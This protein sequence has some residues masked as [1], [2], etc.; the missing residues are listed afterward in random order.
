MIMSLRTSVRFASIAFCGA[1]AFSATASSDTIEQPFL[2]S[3][4]S[5]LDENGAFTSL[6]E[7]SYISINL[8]AYRSEV[9][10]RL[11]EVSNFVLEADNPEIEFNHDEIGLESAGN[12]DPT[13]SRNPFGWGPSLLDSFVS[14]GH[15]WSDPLLNTTVLS[16]SGSE[17]DPDFIFGESISWANSDPANGQG[18]TNPDMVFKEMGIGRFVLDIDEYR[19]CSRLRISADITYVNRHEDFSSVAAV[20]ITVGEEGC[21]LECSADLD[22]NDAVDGGD[23]ATL[24]GEWGGS[25]S[26]D[27][28]G[29]GIVDGAD[30]SQLLGLWGPCSE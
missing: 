23:L 4:E 6:D 12:W 14:I 17:S 1:A 18:D 16:S 22:G 8:H 24:L 25:G 28:N 19:N 30:L 3:Y 15:N 11:I 13:K 5:Y 21:A 20:F 27:L 9:D 7:A 10:F 26:S 29:N 2:I